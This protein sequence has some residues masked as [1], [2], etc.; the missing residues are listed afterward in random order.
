[1]SDVLLWAVFGVLCLAVPAIAY[2]GWML[3][4]PWVQ[5]GLTTEDEPIIT[6]FDHHRHTIA[7][8]YVWQQ[9]RDLDSEFEREFGEV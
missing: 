8:V 4:T 1:M 3:S 2:A 9:T 5:V 6:K 7:E